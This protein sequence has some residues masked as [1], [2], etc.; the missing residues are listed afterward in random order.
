MPS[1]FMGWVPSQLR[2]R[3][4]AINGSISVFSNAVAPRHLSLLNTGNVAKMSRDVLSLT[5]T[6]DC[7]N[8][9]YA[10]HLHHFYVSRMLTLFGYARV[11]KVLVKRILRVYFYFLECG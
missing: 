3:L 5:Y 1:E 2:E 9:E 11:N 8:I 10:N 4:G 7:E 6:L